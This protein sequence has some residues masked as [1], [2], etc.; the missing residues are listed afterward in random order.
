MSRNSATPS[1][2]VVVTLLLSSTLAVQA[3]PATVSFMARR[4]FPIGTSGVNG[5]E[6]VAVGDFKRDRPRRSDVHIQSAE[7]D[8]DQLRRGL[9]GRL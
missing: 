1:A 7:R 6:S 2:W 4:D 9:L 3:S 5:S 8:A